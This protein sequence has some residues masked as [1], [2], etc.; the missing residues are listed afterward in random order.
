M[1]SLTTI[2]CSGWYAAL[3]K[4]AREEEEEEEEESLFRS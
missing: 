3:R 4:R 2:E 1:C